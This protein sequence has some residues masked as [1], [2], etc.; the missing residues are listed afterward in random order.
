MPRGEGRMLKICEDADL[1]TV[2][3]SVTGGTPAPSLKLHGQ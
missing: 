3:F 1:Q 2:K